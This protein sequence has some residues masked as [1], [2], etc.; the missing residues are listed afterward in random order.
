MSGF[1]IENLLKREDGE[2]RSEKKRYNATE[3]TPWRL[4]GG[5]HRCCDA[6]ER[7]VS[8]LGRRPRSR[9][10]LRD[11]SYKKKQHVYREDEFSYLY[12]QHQINDHASL[13]GAKMSNVCEEDLSCQCEVCVCVMCYEWFSSW[14][15][16]YTR[17]YT[18]QLSSRGIHN[19]KHSIRGIYELIK[20]FATQGGS[21]KLLLTTKESIVSNSIFLDHP[22]YFLF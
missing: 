15:R 8:P 5:R 16:S 2:C 20:S 17:Y 22:V 6:E 13:R 9:S 21:Q 4:E 3:D 11:F 7:R 19:V 18:N 12:Q 14:K 1:L 10:P